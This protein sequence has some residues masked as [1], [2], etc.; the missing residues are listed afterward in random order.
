MSRFR[1]STVTWVCF[2]LA[3][4]SFSSLH[5]QDDE[6]RRLAD[7]HYLPQTKEWL[8]RGE[9][10]QVE[11]VSAQFIERGQT[12]PQWQILRLRAMEALGR[13]DEVVEELPD[14][15][16]KHGEDLPFLA[17]AHRFYADFG[18][19]EKAGEILQKV[20]SIA[21]TKSLADRS[22][23][24]LVA[25]GQ[26][27][28]AMGADPNKVMDQFYETAK[29][30]TPE[31]IDTYLAAG[32]LALTKYD[33]ARAAKEFRL[34]LKQ[35]PQ[36][37]DLRYGLARALFPGDR[38]E[39]LVQ[40]E[41]TLYTNSRHVGALLLQT[42]HSLNSERYGEAEALV[43]L[44]NGI[45]ESNPKAWAFRVVIDTLRD[46]NLTAAEASMERALRLRPENPEVPHLVGRCLSRRYRFAQSAELQKQALAWDES[47]TP[48]RLQLASDLLR[49]GREEEAWVLAEE[50]A[51]ADPYNVLAYNY[52]VLRDQ[53]AKYATRETE[54]FILKMLPGEMEIFGDRA[55]DL[56]EEARE[57][58]C[59]KYGLE[60]EEK[61]LVE[62]FGEQ[63]DFAIRTFGELGGAG[64]LGV[65]FGTV[66]TMNSPGS[67]A[68]NMSN[69]EATLWHEFCHVVTLT[70]TR[71]HMPRWLSEG[72]SVYEEV[73]RQEIWGQHMSPRYR[74]R[75]LDPQGITPVSQ[76]SSAFLNAKSGEDVMFAYF[77]SA[78]VVEFLIQKYGQKALNEILQELATGTPVNDAIAA[79]TEDMEALEEH[80]VTFAQEKANA[81]GP[82]LDWTKPEELN[83]TDL[84]SMEAALEESPKN[85]WIRQ[86]YTAA[87]LEA[88]TWNAAAKSAQAYIDLLPEYIGP[89]NGYRMLATAYRAMDQPAK[90]AL[91]LRKLARL[92]ATATPAYQRLLEIDLADKNWE[93]LLENA[94]RQL[95]V[96][97]FLK[98]A[99]Y[100]RACAAQGLGKEEDAIYSFEKLLKLGPSS[101][102]EVNFQL[103]KLYLDDNEAQA[104]RYLLDSLVDAPRFR[105]AHS[106]LLNLSDKPEEPAPEPKPKPK[107]PVPAPSPEPAAKPEAKAIPEPKSEPETQS[108]PVAKP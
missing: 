92:D 21:L 45:Q 54:H 63:Q 51:E 70:L 106:M 94:D 25:L 58:L 84:S 36:D 3:T 78:M 50:V 98:T 4:L 72:I 46:N 83:P 65:C 64:Y 62:V 19:K 85:F 14:L 16:E 79:Y 102:A 34:G 23:A 99:H 60:L 66:I 18:E 1:V 74:E 57:V 104:K 48:A 101:P 88:R 17:E 32:E 82:D 7:E 108:E 97:P 105:E 96:D 33:Y 49:L 12:N 5:A 24:E 10:R 43:N 107:E 9:Y 75:I 29:K 89:N 71:N 11:G 87:L 91:T 42:E 35:A 8:K 95:A 27:A 39:A 15:L 56:L 103:A 44:V 41:R 69:W 6:Y 22:A 37:P 38:E 52:T 61:T 55:L 80:F 40:I 30:R 67:S 90:E 86:A 13:L 31:L 28:F 68:S 26:T 20:N 81:Y 47:F 2:L 53:L 100:C 93:P 77:Q 59:E 73:E 76:L